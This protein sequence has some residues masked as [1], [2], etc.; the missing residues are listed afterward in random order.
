MMARDNRMFSTQTS[1]CYFQSTVG[2]VCK[3]GASERRVPTESLLI[4]SLHFED[5]CQRAASAS[6]SSH[7]QSLTPGWPCCLPDL[8][9]SQQLALQPMQ[10]E[11]SGSHGKHMLGVGTPAAGSGRAELWWFLLP[12]FLGFSN[13]PNSFM[14]GPVLD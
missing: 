6:P 2:W 1:F 13:F 5:K 11:G 8:L 12:T 3:C 7:T 9:I 4:P 10:R 14:S